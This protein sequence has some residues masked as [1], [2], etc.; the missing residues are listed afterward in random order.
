MLLDQM[1]AK[2]LDI[3]DTNLASV[4]IYCLYG[5]WEDLEVHRR[6]GDVDSVRSRRLE[7]ERHARFR[8]GAWIETDFSCVRWMGERRTPFDRVAW[9]ETPPNLRARRVGLLR[10]TRFRSGAWIETP[11]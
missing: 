10:R 9:I 6:D 3:V 8:P 5:P 4:R 1:R 7:L 11:S 2:L